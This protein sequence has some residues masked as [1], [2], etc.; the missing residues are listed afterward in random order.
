VRIKFYY[1]TPFLTVISLKAALYADY[2]KLILSCFF[3]NASSGV[4]DSNLGMD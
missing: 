1:L 4:N 3:L 2:D